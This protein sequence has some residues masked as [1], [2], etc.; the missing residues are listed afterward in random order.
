MELADVLD[1]KSSGSDTVPV[2]PR[3][4]APTEFVHPVFG[5]FYFV[6]FYIYLHF[7]IQ[8]KISTPLQRL[9]I[10]K[11]V[12][13]QNNIFLHNNSLTPA[14]MRQHYL[15]GLPFLVS[16]IYYFEVRCSF[17]VIKILLCRSREMKQGCR[18][19]RLFGK[20]IRDF[21]ARNQNFLMN[22]QPTTG[23]IFV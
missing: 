17:V 19:A 11:A 10:H 23:F 6:I 1:S 8:Y 22:T 13:L 9:S 14:D 7:Y 16:K 5:L 21:Y 15:W 3:P 12:L 4:P 2:R 20:S 18:L